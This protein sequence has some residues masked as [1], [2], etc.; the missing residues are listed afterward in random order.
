MAQYTSAVCKY[1]H[2]YSSGE[3]YEF[4][5]LVYSIELNYT[6]PQ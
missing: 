6:S 1:F 2:S 3:N 4:N 5:Q